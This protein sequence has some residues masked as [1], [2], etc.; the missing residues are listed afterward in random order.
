MKDPQKDVV[1]KYHDGD[2]GHVIMLGAT[3]NTPTLA[4]V[5]FYEIGSL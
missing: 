2:Y 5:F 3:S 1:A 4:S